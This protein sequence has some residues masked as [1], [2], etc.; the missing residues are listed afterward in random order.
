MK[1]RFLILL[2]CSSVLIAC[3]D[4]VKKENETKTVFKYNEPAG[5]TSLDP[6]FSRTTE[7][8]WAVNQLF[9][10]LVQ[11]NDQLEV[12]PCI[13]RSW[14]ISDNGLEYTF[15]LRDDVFFHDHEKFPNGKG[16]KVVANDFV[17]SFYRIIDKEV[18]SPGSWIFNNLNR[19]SD[20]SFFGFTAPND[21]TFKIF[22]EKPFPPFLGLLS[23]QYCSVV[24]LEIVEYYGNDFRNNPI[25]TGPFKFKMWKEGEKL[26]FLK[27][28][29]YFE[30]DEKGQQLP[31]L[32]AV[33]ISFIRDRQTA[34]LDFIKGNFDFLSEVDASF[35]DDILN[36]AGKVNEK[37]DGKIKLNRHPYLKVDYLGFMIN[38]SKTTQDNPL[39]KKKV[40][41]AINMGIN[42][43][44]MITYLRNNIGNAATSGFIPPGMPSFDEKQVK[45]YS[46]D[47]DRAREL[48]KE[49]GYPGGEGLPVITLSATS[50]YLDLLEFVQKELKS[51][52]IN[53]KIDV[54]S[55]AAFSEMVA[56]SAVPFFRKS[57]IA[58]YPDAENFLA[59]FYSKNLSPE[60]P[61]YTHFQNKKFDELYERARLELDEKIRYD[62]Y[63]MMDQLIIDEAPV[64]PLYY[65]EAVT[66]IRS[67]ISGM[68]NN[69]MKLMVLKNVKKGL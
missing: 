32:D 38:P 25:G 39:L 52:G 58:D 69:P 26:I 45:G 18:A 35:K 9:N 54:L 67:N 8:I 49:A 62:L 21:T 30:K 64:V 17:N 14:E 48:L 13:A 19:N 24:P 43:E 6:A 31:Y 34:Y 7:N 29:N 60:G 10:G 59:P 42:R 56:R 33:A 36:R 5:I 68:S 4:D 65:D 20:N 41:Q 61:N 57:W 46:Y 47:P 66:F 23:M 12:K 3:K 28:P 50:A 1:N 40:R 55:T 53:I 44:K 16:R 63:R 51:I 37:Y 2:F 22:L 15:Y 11:M 27:N